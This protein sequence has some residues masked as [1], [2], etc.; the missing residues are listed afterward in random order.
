MTKNKKIQVGL[1][2]SLTISLV[3]AVLIPKAM[4]ASILDPMNFMLEGFAK[5]FDNVILR[6]LSLILALGGKLFDYA[7]SIT[8]FTGIQAVQSGWIIIRDFVNISFIFILLIIAI[9]TIL[10]FEEYGMKKLFVRLVAVALLVNFS[11][12]MCTAI[13]DT[14]NMLTMFFVDGANLNNTGI[15][16]RIMAGLGVQKIYAASQSGGLGGYGNALGNVIISMI[17]SFA[18]MI[19]AVIVM[20]LAAGLLFVR[21]IV[22][23]FLV[24]LSPAAFL[25]RILPNTKEYWSKWWKMFIGQCLFAPAFAFFMYLALFA[26]Q[27]SMDS[28]GMA[29]AP[30]ASSTLM[31]QI[32]TGGVIPGMQSGPAPSMP[33]MGNSFFSAGGTIIHYIFFMG[34]IIAAIYMAVQCK[35][36][37]GAKVYG[38]ATAGMK[39]FSGYN[40]AGRK[41]KEALA[42]ARSGAK[43][44]ASNKF[45]KA[46]GAIGGLGWL[47]KDRKWYNPVRW[48]TAPVTKTAKKAQVQSLITERKGNKAIIDKYSDWKESELGNYWKNLSKREQAVL[49]A[50]KAENK[51]AHKLKLNDGVAETTI[52]NMPKYQADYTEV[53]KYNPSLV[54]EML[55][56]Y[57]DKNS[58][59]IND[60]I[61]KLQNDSVPGDTNT[62]KNISTIEF[63]FSK[64]GSSDMTGMEA[65][66]L[67]DENTKQAF[68]ASL[69]HN[70]IDKRHIASILSS[71]NSNLINKVAK[72][73]KDNVEFD[74][75]PEEFR[76]YWNAS[77]V[78]GLSQPQQQ[79]QSTASAPA[80]AAPAPG[81]P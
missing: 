17:M 40:F 78:Q 79:Q 53:F 6:G 46:T 67:D 22:L 59:D 30:G 35:A 66:A 47:N 7:L 57:Y 50:D 31:A 1:I 25:F 16:A 5:L 69:R 3:F 48:A 77:F 32:G 23:S 65:G 18:V 13:I 26:A 76:N 14:T 49:L 2:F 51:K 38:M 27:T 71:D 8:K 41:G 63:A 24:I 21:V 81:T 52:K 56:E 62:I 55:P 37:G 4:A 29:S 75:L 43:R 60:I 80:P 28:G 12:L 33:Q 34:F 74:K 54:M 45:A 15:S 73:M 42:G 70:K 61:Q 64:M 44:F 9:S 68:Y 10:G 19:G 20:W 39:K 11:M 58:D 72:L 36:V